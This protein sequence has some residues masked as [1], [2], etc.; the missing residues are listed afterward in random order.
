MM[1]WKRIT[2]GKG[3]NN[4]WKNTEKCLYSDQFFV[5]LHPKWIIKL[6]IEYFLS[7]TGTSVEARWQSS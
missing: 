3:T 7:V 6:N 2:E 1:I 5:P 4:F